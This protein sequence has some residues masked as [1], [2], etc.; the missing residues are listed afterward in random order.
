M[1]EISPIAVR[2]SRISAAAFTGRAAAPTSAG[3]DP[4][5]QQLLSR[6][7]LQLAVVSNQIQSLGAQ[8]NQLSNSLA[9]VRNSLATSQALERQKERQEQVLEN[10]LAQQKLREGKESVVEKKIQAKVLSPALKL[11]AKLQTS[12]GGLFG[13]FQR[14]FFGWLAIKGVETIQALADGNYEK[15][16]EIKKSVLVAVGGFIGL[17]LALKAATGG[18]KGKFNKISLLLT[19]VAAIA[20]FREPIGEFFKTVGAFVDELTNNRLSQLNQNFQSWVEKNFPPVD[21][22]DP[23]ALPDPGETQKK[24]EEYGPPQMLPPVGIGGGDD[25]VEVEKP[26]PFLDLRTLFPQ[27]APPEPQ[28]EPDILKQKIGGRGFTTF[29]DIIDPTLDAYKPFQIPPL[30]PYNPIKPSDDKPTE[31]SPE[32]D[33]KIVPLKVIPY[34]RGQQEGSEEPKVGDKV[35]DPEIL[36]MIEQEKEIGRTGKIDPILSKSRTV[37]ETIS[38]ASRPTVNV[39]PVPM[40]DGEETAQEAPASGGN[41][42]ASPGIIASHN[43][44]NPYILGALAQYNVIA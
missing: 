14:L 42:A 3:I 25:Q 35:T 19:G 10:R 7:T 38:Q 27:T 32:G 29:G 44:D 23:D 11:G 5:S 34:N 37:S 12:L 21:Q 4:Q 26:K 8:V 30:P 6:N 9:V 24:F 40:N 36:K 33:K 28:P 20:L 39:I 13:F 18:F 31:T 15:L 2:R 16:E 17:K 22:G 1:V 43:H 41:I